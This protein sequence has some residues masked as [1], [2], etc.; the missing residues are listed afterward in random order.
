MSHEEMEPV[1]KGSKAVPLV[2]ANIIERDDTP[3]AMAIAL[4]SPSNPIWFSTSICGLFQDHNARNDCCA[5]NCCGILSLDRTRYLLTKEKPSW[6]R[7][8]LLYIVLPWVSM[9]LFS[10]FIYYYIATDENT[11]ST[12]ATIAMVVYILWI[13]FF[14]H[15]W[16]AYRRETREIVIRKIYQS[17]VGSHG[18]PQG[19]LQF[20]QNHTYEIEKA[21]PC[22]CGCSCCEC[23]GCGKYPVAYDLVPMPR[24]E[25][26]SKDICSG[27]WYTAYRLCGLCQCFGICAIGQEEREANR[28]VSPQERLI[29]YVT[30]QPFDRYNSEIVALRSQRNNSLMA[31][32]KA[33]SSLSSKLLKALGIYLAITLALALLELNISALGKLSVVSKGPWTNE[34]N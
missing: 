3:V 16:R 30:Y 17:H 9:Q 25:E 24:K 1:L 13:S 18:N 4:P 26:Y 32:F 19:E 20:L 21:H 6:V 34:W 31:H 33:I 14:F 7:R 27:F 28:L 5:L 23:L 10:S 2:T 22:C 8:I 11:A 29:D 12:I 15:T